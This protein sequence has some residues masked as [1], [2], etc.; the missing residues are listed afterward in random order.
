MRVAG[1]KDAESWKAFFETL[2]GA[3]EA[4]VAD[5]DTAIARAVRETWPDALLLPSRHHLA[6]LLHARAVEDGVPERVR[7]ETPVTLRRP[8]P[9]TS[10]PTKRWGEHP[11]HAAM[12]PALRGP[13]EWAALLGLVERHVPADK[14]ALRSWTATNEPLVRRAWT[15]AARHRD[16][17]L[18]TGALEGS[19]GEWLAPIARRAGRW[20]NARRLDLVLALMTLRARGEAREARYARIVRRAVRGPGNYA[21]APDEHP[22]TERWRIW[23]DHGEPS[24]PHLVREADR[25]WRRRAEDDQAGRAKERL[26]GRYAAEVDLRERLGLPLPPSGRPKRPHPRTG[27]VRGHHL[28]RLPGP[29]RRVGLGHQRRPG[30]RAARGREPRAGRLALPARAGAR[31]G[32]RVADRTSR[33][34]ACPYHMGVRVHPAESLAAFFP[35]L[36]LEWHPTRNALRPDQVSRASAREVIWRCEQGHGWSA[37]VYQR[38]SHA[39]GV[40]SATGRGRRPLHGRQGAGPPDAGRGSRGGPAAGRHPGRRGALSRPRSDTGRSTQPSS[41]PFARPGPRS[42][43]PSGHTK[44]GLIPPRYNGGAPHLTSPP[45]H[46]LIIT[47]R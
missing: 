33:G 34:A 32:G 7:L 20:Q 18:S 26:V 15:I 39:P 10:E 46:G 19:I 35:W 24:L 43:A 38:T 25:R 41:A 17:P 9:W 21:H 23:R 36:A 8:L 30:P 28:G 12:L 47:V 27:S 11:L 29:A 4:V 44:A 14:L 5:L 31:V 42:P 22:A 1:A 37:A 45:V 13:T 3:P 40:R 16:L 2:Q 6:A